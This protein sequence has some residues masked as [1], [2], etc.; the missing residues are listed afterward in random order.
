VSTLRRRGFLVRFTM[1]A[2]LT[3]GLAAVVSAASGLRFTTELSGA[4]EV[5]T[6]DP[7]GHGRAH[8]T[9]DVATGQVCFDVLVNQSGTPNRAHIHVGDAGA[10]GGIVVPFFEL[11]GQPAN[12]L[13]D[14]LERNGRATGCVEASPDLLA[15]IVANPSGYYVNL[16]N[17][18]FP[19]GAVRGQLSD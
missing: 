8:V 19:A 13:N 7:D 12:P 17:A 9:I 18:R 2:A 1:I 16:H 6:A 11:I 3:L 14:A 4:N 10:N 15:Q 5:P